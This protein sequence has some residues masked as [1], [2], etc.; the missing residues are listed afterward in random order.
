VSTPAVPLATAATSYSGGDSL[1]MSGKADAESSGLPVMINVP[2]QWMGVCSYDEGKEDFPFKMDVAALK[3]KEITGTINWPT[4]GNAKTKFR[5]KIEGNNFFF[6]E[7]EAVSGAEDVQIPSYYTGKISSQGTAINGSTKGEFGSTSN[8]DED[9]ATFHLTLLEEESSS[10]D[11]DVAF[12][13]IKEGSEFTGKSYTE[14]PFTI[15]FSKR[16]GDMIEGSITWKTQNCKTNFKGTV[17]SS[18]IKFEEYE[19]AKKSDDDMVVPV[20]MIY[21]GNWDSSQKFSISG[22]SGPA[23][24][25][26]HQ[27]F[28]IKL[29]P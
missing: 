14:Y 8:D 24:N 25:K 17:T 9:D 19:I 1:K 26:L 23:V 10:S 11:E 16:K 12:P 21:T 20:P 2:S 15:K 4:L 22:S 28:E 3:G 7:Y 27:K 18:G 5:G 6:E 13:D 29:T